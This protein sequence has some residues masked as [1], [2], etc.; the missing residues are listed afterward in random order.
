MLPMHQRMVEDGI[1]LIVR[2]QKASDTFRGALKSGD[3]VDGFEFYFP[4]EEMSDD[5]CLQLHRESGLHFPDYYELGIQHVGDCL[6]CTA[7]CVDDRRVGY[8]KSRHPLRF[9]DFRREMLTIADAVEQSSIGL[10]ETAD[11]CL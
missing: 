7:W 8:I 10:F 5:E 9:H 3:V 2:G 11:A 6:G 4:T 1:T